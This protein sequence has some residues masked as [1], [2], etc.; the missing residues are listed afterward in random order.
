M[1]GS[2]IMKIS[3]GMLGGIGMIRYH[4]WYLMDV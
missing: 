2:M 4:T 3:S 1:M